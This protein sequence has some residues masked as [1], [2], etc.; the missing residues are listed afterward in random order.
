MWIKVEVKLSRGTKWVIGRGRGR[1]GRE[2]QR[3]GGGKGRGRGGGVGGIR[4]MYEIYLHEHLKKSNS[5]F[6]ILS[7]AKIPTV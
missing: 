7:S 6:L 3:R 2:R 5:N 4:Q 1:G